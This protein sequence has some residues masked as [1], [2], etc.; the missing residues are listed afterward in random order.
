MRA[1]RCTD[2][3]RILQTR[4]PAKL[5]NELAEVV[6]IQHLVSA[7]WVRAWR[8]RVFWDEPVPGQPPKVFLET[9]T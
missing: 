2:K 7:E 9:A 4:W 8:W 5:Q 1:I 3:N 6:L